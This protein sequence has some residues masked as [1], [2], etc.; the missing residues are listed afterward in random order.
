MN[1]KKLAV[2]QDKKTKS[3]FICP[4]EDKGGKFVTRDVSKYGTA[5]SINI[6]D[7]KLGLEIKRQLEE[8]AK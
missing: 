7:A 1:S 2:Y 6:S 4:M 5:V 3:I 8:E